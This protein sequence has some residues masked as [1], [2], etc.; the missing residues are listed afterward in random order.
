MNDVTADDVR[1]CRL[2]VVRRFKAKH[3]LWAPREW[4]G[5]PIM[6]TKRALQGA[7][8]FEEAVESL[9]PRPMAWLPRN[10]RPSA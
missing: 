10:L 6:E 9:I 5:P 2:E 7:A 4:H 8:T 1:R 3:P